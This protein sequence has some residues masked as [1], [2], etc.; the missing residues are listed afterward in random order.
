M[1]KDKPSSLSMTAKLHNRRIR[2]AKMLD[3]DHFIFIFRNLM[4]RKEYDSYNITPPSEVILRQTDNYVLFSNRI[5]LSDEAVQ[6]MYN[7]AHTISLEE[8]I[9]KL[10]Q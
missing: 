7:L 6:A 1:S 2:C 4:S 9:H 5:D 3:K 10:K 8:S